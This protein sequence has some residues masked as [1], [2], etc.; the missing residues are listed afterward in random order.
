MK[1]VIFTLFFSSPA[2]WPSP[3]AAASRRRKLRPRHWSGHHDQERAKILITGRRRRRLRRRRRRGFM[4]QAQSAQQRL[5]H[6]PAPP[7]HSQVPR[8]PNVHRREE[9]LASVQLNLVIFTLLFCST[10]MCS[11]PAGAVS[12]RRRKLSYRPGHHDQVPAWRRGHGPGQ[13]NLVLCQV[14]IN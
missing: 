8:S 12:R 14:L 1:L 11:S 2:E 4:P 3:A 10:A 7:S 9:L 6:A 5:K 13:H